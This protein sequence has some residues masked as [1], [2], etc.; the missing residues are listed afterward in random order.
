MRDKGLED[1]TTQVIDGLDIEQIKKL[2]P[3]RYPFLL[4]DRVLSVEPGKKAT[5]FK[6]LTANEPFFQGHFPFRGIMPGVLMV[7][8]LAQLASITILTKG[9]F[10]DSLGV[11]TGIDGF[12]FRT[13]VEPGDRLDLEVEL[14]KMRGPLGK[15][16]GVAKVEGKVAAEG[17]ISFSILDQEKV[18]NLKR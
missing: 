15:M 11:F 7:E 14:I 8:A 18:K 17:E 3:H 1:M 9:E 5:G 12:K 6:N 4:I 2:L 13:M 10:K 16:R